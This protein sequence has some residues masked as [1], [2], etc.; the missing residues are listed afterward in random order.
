MPIPVLVIVIVW[1]EV[2]YALYGTRGVVEIAIYTARGVAECCIVY[3][4]RT[5]STLLSQYI[6]H[7]PYYELCIVLH[8][9]IKGTA[10]DKP[11]QNRF[12][13]AILDKPLF[14]TPKLV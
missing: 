6:T 10:Q 5:S 3:R 9:R 2:M 14:K 7:L 12:E 4:D 8:G 13:F 11:V 1:K